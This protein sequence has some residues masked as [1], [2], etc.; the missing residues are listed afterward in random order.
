MT[1]QG[2]LEKEGF[3][4]TQ[5]STSTLDEMPERY[6]ERAESIINEIEQIE[7]NTDEF[8]DERRGELQQAVEQTDSNRTPSED[9]NITMHERMSELLEKVEERPH[10][11][12][13]ET[14]ERKN[15]RVRRFLERS[16]QR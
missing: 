4:A 11:F 7:S 8:I 16:A 12:V 6:R 1:V 9:G 3:D 2:A 15:E 13:Q 14:I 5:V 10:E